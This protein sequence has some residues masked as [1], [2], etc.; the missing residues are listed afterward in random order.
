MIDWKNNV[1]EA[2][3]IAHAINKFGTYY[4]EKNTIVSQ[5]SHSLKKMNYKVKLKNFSSG[6]NIIQINDKLYGGSD[7]RREGIAIGNL[8]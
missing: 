4:L 1:Q 5:L 6:L 3:S 7:H 2:A 8:H